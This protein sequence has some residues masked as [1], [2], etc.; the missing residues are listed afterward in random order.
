MPTGHMKALEQAVLLG[1]L[2]WERP[3][4]ERGFYP[5][6]MPADWRLTFYNTQFDCVFVP[7]AQWREATG[8]VM[9]Q[10]AEDTH[11]RFLFLL[12]AEDGMSVPAP[13]QGKALC[14]S[15]LDGRI[16]WF[17][18]KSD[19]KQLAERIRQHKDGPL[20]LLSRDA[21]LPQLERVRTLLGLLGMGA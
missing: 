19:L 16:D 15:A 2:G 8:E 6:D 4:W 12:E 17:D 10:W 13:L 5:E 7:A 14:L 9:G 3:E 18:G 1:V 21:D 11:D 20:F